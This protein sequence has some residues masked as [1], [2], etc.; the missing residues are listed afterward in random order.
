LEVFDSGEG[1]GFCA[2]GEVDSR[3]V[4]L[5]EAEDGLFA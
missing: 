5:G 1:F 2:R 4:V 3:G